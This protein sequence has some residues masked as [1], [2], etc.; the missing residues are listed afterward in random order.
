[1]FHFLA[2]SDIDVLTLEGAELAA[3]ENVSITTGVPSGRMSKDAG[4]RDMLVV[5]HFVDGED[6]IL[7][8]SREKPSLAPLCFK[9]PDL[10]PC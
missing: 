8:Y 7:L 10:D 6:L 5:G 3:Y 1:M 9:G 2:N 4:D